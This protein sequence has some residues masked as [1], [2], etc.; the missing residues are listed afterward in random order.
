MLAGGVL[1]VLLGVIIV[2]GLEWL[3]SDVVR[4]NE[5]VERYIGLPVIGSIPTITTREGAPGA[6]P[7][8][9]PAFWNR[10]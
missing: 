1:G 5:D 9:R 2:L 3:E 4:S 6:A 8:A 7:R 10:V